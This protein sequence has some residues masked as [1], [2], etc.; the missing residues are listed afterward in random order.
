MSLQW[1]TNFTVFITFQEFYVLL[2]KYS[3]E[4]TKNVL[5]VTKLR[6]IITF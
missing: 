6:Q 3:L 2:Y 5:R 4:Q 1:K